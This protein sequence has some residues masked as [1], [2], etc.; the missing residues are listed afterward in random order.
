MHIIPGSW[1]EKLLRAAVAFTFIYPAVSAWFNP[2]AWVGYFPSFLID[3]AGNYDLVLLHA[4]GV[5]ELFIAAWLLFGRR[6]L[7]PCMLA[8]AYLLGI[9]VF[10]WNQL[11]VIFRDIAFMLA[12]AALALLERERGGASLSED[13]SPHEAQ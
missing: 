4:F 11:D 5:T 13:S 9:V 1:S 6:I 3:L 12:T 2:Y 7:V 10:N 8:I